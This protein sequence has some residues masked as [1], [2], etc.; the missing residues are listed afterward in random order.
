[1]VTWGHRVGRVL[2]LYSPNPSPAGVCDPTPPRF[3]GEGHTRWRER[4]WGSP[5]SDEGTYAVVLLIYI[6]C[7]AEGVGEGAIPNA[8]FLNYFCSMVKRISPGAPPPPP[9]THQETRESWS[10]GMDWWGGG[11]EGAGGQIASRVVKIYESIAGVQAENYTCMTCL[12]ISSNTPFVKKTETC[13]LFRI[14]KINRSRFFSIFVRQLTDFA[15]KYTCN[16]SILFI[17]FYC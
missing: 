7:V 11:G 15:I 10:G 12:L 9:P 1:M 17:Y 2:R 5:N 6:Y 8:V 14:Q 4:G 3:W 13:I 16:N